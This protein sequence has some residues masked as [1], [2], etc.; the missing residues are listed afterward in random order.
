MNRFHSQVEASMHP[1]FFWNVL[2][3]QAIGTSQAQ[4]VK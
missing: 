1:E 2:H 3:R 4:I